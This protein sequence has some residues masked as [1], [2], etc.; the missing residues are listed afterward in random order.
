MTETPIVYEF[1]GSIYDKRDEFLERLVL[2]YTAGNRD[3]VMATL[4]EYGLTLVDIGIIGES[5]GTH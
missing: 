4:E 1:G 2:E 5:H 3:V